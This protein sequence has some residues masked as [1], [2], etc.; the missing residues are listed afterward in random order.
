MESYPKL[1]ELAHVNILQLLHNRRAARDKKASNNAREAAL[2]TFKNTNSSPS[3][4][5]MKFKPA[6]E[7]SILK[8]AQPKVRTPSRK[9]KPVK[10]VTFKN[11]SPSKRRNASRR[12]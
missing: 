11:H 12:R 4:W 3:T 6:N 9:T 7:R 10:R 5:K 8:G 1:A 2:Q